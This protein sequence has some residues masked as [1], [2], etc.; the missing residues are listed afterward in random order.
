[1]NYYELVQLA[2]KIIKEISHLVDND[3]V[4]ESEY[5]LKKLREIMINAEFLKDKLLRLNINDVI[6]A[7]EEV[8]END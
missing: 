4:Y 5:V 3:T 6:I 8:E 1:M 2:D 7:A